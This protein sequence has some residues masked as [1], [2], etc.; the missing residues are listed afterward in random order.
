MK[1]RTRSG[2]IVVGVILVVAAFRGC[3]SAPE[4]RPSAAPTVGVERVVVTGPVLGPDVPP[5]DT[6]VPL[7]TNTPA[8]V[9]TDTPVPL[10]T[11]TPDLGLALYAVQLQEQMGR[12][13]DAMGTFSELMGNPD[14][15]NESWMIDVAVQLVAIRQAHA[16]LLAIDAPDGWQEIHSLTI[17][18]TGS[19]NDATYLVAAGIDA[20][21]V[22]LLQQATAQIGECTNGLVV[23]KE[24]LAQ[25]VEEL[26]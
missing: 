22:G 21:D 15:G 19:C 17:S 11:N 2:V 4:A 13:S 10:P 26:Q 5:T 7:P 16:A 24:A 6:P 1:R 25:R 18:A 20:L 9:A 23:A 3:G 8:P 12:L 14:V